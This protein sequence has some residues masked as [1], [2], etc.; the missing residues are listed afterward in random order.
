MNTVDI[1]GWIAGALVLTTFCLR[2]MIP[3][4]GVAIASNIAFVAYG[5]MASTLPIVVLH[6]ALLP[7]NLLRLQEMRS[8]ISR[9]KRASR[10]A[11]CLDMLVPH[12]QLR[13]VPAGTTL[14]QKGEHAEDMYLVLEGSVRIAGKNALVKAGELIGEMGIFAPGQRRTDTAVCKSDVCLASI[15]NDK[16]WE[17]F[18]GTPEFG[19][20]LLRL[21]VLRCHERQ[22]DCPDARVPRQPLVPIRRC[23]Y[24]TKNR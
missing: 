17:L 3:L 9:V 8:L 2:T 16:I 18:Y 24:P 21:M 20:H 12:M 5:L 1:F 11:L 23:E 6:L 22:E 19:A 14:F 10:G 7:M 13:Q 15:T 4:R